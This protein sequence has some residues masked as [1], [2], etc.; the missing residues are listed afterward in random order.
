MRMNRGYIESGKCLDSVMNYPL[1][2]ALIRYF[3]YND[4]TKLAYIIKDIKR[5]YPKDTIN[6]LMNFTST[7][8][9][10]RAINIF[11][12]YDFQEY[13]E[14]AW[15][16]NN[17]DLNWCKNFKLTKE[18]YDHGKEIYKAYVFALTFMPGILSIFY[19]DEIGIEGIGNLANR[20]TY[21]WGKEDI[22]LLNYFKYIGSIRKQESF[23]Q[24]AELNLL[25]IN[26]NYFMFERY[27]KE[28]RALITISRTQEETEF[29]VP[30]EYQ[31]KTKVYTL[32]KSK[33]GYLSP[34]GA[35]AIKK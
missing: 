5:E 1:I 27:T 30:K 9:I 3:K 13:G 21:P 17:N 10:S 33:Q 29:Y 8:D 25:D 32:N 20:K 35:I 34:Y 15:N 2:D 14:W 28:D 7:H 26:Q 22:E 12:T 16:L 6:T 24:E 31:N 11:S 18:Q 19:G 4:I 23:L